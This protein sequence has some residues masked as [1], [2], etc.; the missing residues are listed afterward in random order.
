MIDS[1]SF[2]FLAKEFKSIGGSLMNCRPI[3]SNEKLIKNINNDGQPKIIKEMYLPNPRSGHFLRVTIDQYMRIRIKGSLR[4][5]FYGN[6]SYKD[7]SKQHYW[8]AVEELANSLN[9][10][11]ADIMNYGRLTHIE[12]G[13][14]IQTKTNP[15]SIL[16]RIKKFVRVQTIVDYHNKHET[17]YGEGTDKRL[18][19]YNKSLEIPANTHWKKRGKVVEELDSLSRRGVYLLRVEIEMFYKRSFINYGFREINTL[20]DIYENWENLF[21][22][23]VREYSKIKLI[24]QPELSNRMTP[25][26]LS[27]AKTIIKLKDF[28]KGIEEYAIENGQPI[29][30]IERDGYS[31][32]DRY[33]SGRTYSIRSFRKDIARHL[34]KIHRKE[35]LPLSKLFHLLWR[36]KHGRIIKLADSV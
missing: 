23:M 28:Q 10:S 25:K 33:S 34:I 11:V 36:T 13:C 16:K 18:R 3:S 30:R 15:T 26:E 14:T 6:T 21:A 7:L 22:L 32:L 2:L 17:I 31:L 12:L 1:I 29:K 24:N 9:I 5:W 35:K 19:V 27:L 4:K 8:K 20:N